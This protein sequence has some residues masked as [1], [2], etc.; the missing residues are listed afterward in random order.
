MHVSELG[1]RSYRC[2]S[3]NHDGSWHKLS[4]G[5]PFDPIVHCDNVKTI[6][7]LSL[8]LMDPL[9]LLKG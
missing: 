1:K 9:D 4:I 2:L 3:T 8:V 5:I 6:K 7:E